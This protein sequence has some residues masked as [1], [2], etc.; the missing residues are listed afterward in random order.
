ARVFRQLLTES[1]LLV[2][3]GAGVGWLVAIGAT[4]ALAVWARI[5][6]GL[7]PDQRVLIF[8]L[9]ITC[10]VALLFGLVPLRSAL[11][12]SIEQELRSSTS[13]VGRRRN[14]MFGGNLAVA[15]QV[16]MC[17]P[18]V[19]ASSLS[20]RSLLNY[21]RQDLGMQA[22]SLLIFDLNPHGLNSNRQ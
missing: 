5:E 7:A 6:G 22:E 8:T 19:V 21:K 14:S 20:V 4:K 17:L 10:F 9:S 16:A 3:T 15:M 11:R 13:G 2:S 1:L 18:L 12:I